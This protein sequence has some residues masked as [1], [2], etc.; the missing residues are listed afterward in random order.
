MSAR[1]LEVDGQPAAHDV[2]PSPTPLT[3][4][5]AERRIT[6]GL[7]RCVARWGLSKTTI[8]DL[9]REAGVSRATV[10]RLFPGGKEAVLYVAV[11]VEVQ[12]LLGDLL[13]EAMRA[14]DLE[15]CLVGG[16]HHA[17]V[18]LGEHPAL[19]FL[20]DHERAVLDQVVSFDRL[21]VVLVSA[22]EAL[23]PALERFLDPQDA[24]ETGV[25]CAR[26]VLSYL[27]EPARDVDLRRLEDVQSL[28][29][30]FVLPGLHPVDP[31]ARPR[32]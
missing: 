22:G 27:A 8:D 16:L 9:A 18:F 17:S 12:R 29:R 2:A 15:Q 7:L 5:P 28:V 11:R 32:T 31:T 23:R 10:Y 6:D 14:E 21:D 20:R 3:L 26:L 1:Q 13:A 19:S 25:W 4:T 30:S 24:V